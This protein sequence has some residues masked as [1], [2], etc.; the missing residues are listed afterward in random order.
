MKDK[1][2]LTNREQIGALTEEEDAL[3]MRL[4]EFEKE[5][6]KRQMSIVALRQDLM[7]ELRDVDP[8]LS[9]KEVVG[10]SKELQT[11]YK[12]LHDDLMVAGESLG[13]AVASITQDL[14]RTSDKRKALQDIEHRKVVDAHC[15]KV[16]DEFEKW[17]KSYSVVADLFYNH[18]LTVIDDGYNLDQRFHERG[19]ALGLRTDIFEALSALFRPGSVKYADG[20]PKLNMAQMLMQFQEMRL[21][22]LLPEEPWP[23]PT[24][25]SLF[26][27]GEAPQ[28]SEL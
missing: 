16:W 1:K 3:R 24:G 8:G 18:L 13:A 17:L 27:P 4:G 10:N 26:A 20:Q 25:G 5:E 28:F 11:K 12:G 6:K 19:Q 7:R 22:S 21:V 15:H 14:K 9:P 2:V 23:A